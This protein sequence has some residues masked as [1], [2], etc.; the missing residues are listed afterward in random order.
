MQIFHQTLWQNV[1][2]WKRATLD[3][4]PLHFHDYIEILYIKNGSAVCSVDF[5]EYTLSKDDILFVFPGQIHAVISAT[6]QCENH[7][8]FFPKEIPIFASVFENNIP[9]LPAGH[10]TEEID[11]LFAKALKSYTNY[12]NPYAKG[13]ALGQILILLSKLLPRLE[14]ISQ[15]P[16]DNRIERKIIEYC[17]AH[18]AE[19]LTLTDIATEF[20]YTPSYFSDIFSQKFNGGFLKFI[21]ILRTEE[22]KKHL[23]GNKEISNIAFSCGFG[24]IRTFNRVFKELT[25]KTPREYRLSH[26]KK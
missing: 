12:K 9:T 16:S 10:S 15:I 21:N 13:E 1:H 14:L 8:L 11:E 4:F 23:Q 22:A 20:G 2:V 5:T 6:E 24:S 26:T 17:T 25:G 19:P 18:F 7:V 3:P